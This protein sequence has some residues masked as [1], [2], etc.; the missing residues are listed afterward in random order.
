VLAFPASPCTRE[1]ITRFFDGLGIVEPGIGYLPDWHPDG[2]VPDV[3][4]FSE[5]LYIGGLG[6][7][8]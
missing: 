3:P 5:L 4:G 6:R 8:P 1:E 7:K 2:P